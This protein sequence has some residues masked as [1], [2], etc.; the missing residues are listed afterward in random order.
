MLAFQLPHG[1]G[2]ED[3][4]HPLGTGMPSG[5]P[6]RVDGEGH[7]GAWLRLLRH[8]PCAYCGGP[9]GTVDHVEPKRR[10][11]RGLGGA[12]TWLNVVGAC[13]SCNGRK[14]D[15]PL[16]WFLLHG[17]APAAGAAAHPPRRKR[18]AL[19]SQCDLEPGQWRVV[20]V[21]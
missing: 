2:R 18:P 14:A 10:P 19:G 17:V 7:Y 5:A 6:L 15:K 16:L 9:S 13:T 12:H 8:D 3:A 21:A 4:G 1:F 11:V 20:G